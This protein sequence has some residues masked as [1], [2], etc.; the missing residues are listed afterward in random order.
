MDQLTTNAPE[1]DAQT[2]SFLLAL[3]CMTDEHPEAGAI[4][5]D[6]TSGVHTGYG[7]SLRFKAKEEKHPIE[8]QEMIAKC[9]FSSQ[10]VLVVQYGK[11]FRALLVSLVALK[12]VVVAK[13]TVELE[14]ALAT[15]GFWSR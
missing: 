12:R 8:V 15:L 1:L 3:E 10:R 2:M 5:A 6:I 13:E 11:K 7:L 14:Q 4:Y 9:N